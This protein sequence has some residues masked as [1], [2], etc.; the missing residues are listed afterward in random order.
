MNT[1][2]RCLLLMVFASCILGC[3]KSTKVYEGLSFEEI[4]KIA[5]DQNRNFCIVVSNLECD[6]CYTYENLLKGEYK[7]LSNKA[8]FNVIKTNH[9]DQEWY[10]FWLYTPATPLT[11]IFDSAGNLK[12]IING[13]S[14]K[15]FQAV[16]KVLDGASSQSVL[17]YNSPLKDYLD[18]EKTISVLNDILQCKRALE[19]GK[20]ITES[21]NETLNIAWYPFNVYLSCL[22]EKE[23]ENEE[24]AKHIAKQ[25]LTF[26]HNNYCNYLYPALFAQAHK[27][28]DPNYVECSEHE[29]CSGHDH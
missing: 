2:A 13:A 5:K 27:I 19:K 14:I 21:I 20:D 29:N 4:Q 3:Q 11:C 17:S 8:V 12:S 22:N 18:D 9:Q 1:I 15:S 7:G 10:K 6:A 23:K 28:I 26:Q 25:L 24:N 16:E